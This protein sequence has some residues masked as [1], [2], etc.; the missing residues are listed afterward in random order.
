MKNNSFYE[1]EKKSFNGLDIMILIIA[2]LMVLVVIFRT[3][4]L[5]FFSD[6]ATQTDC[7]I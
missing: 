3:N 7:E 1:D 6:T 5:S 2:V 4:I